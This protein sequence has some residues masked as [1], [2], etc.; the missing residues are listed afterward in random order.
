MTIRAA[1]LLATLATWAGLCA[2]GESGSSSAATSRLTPTADRAEAQANPVAVSPQPGTEDASP[3]TQVSFLGE[4]GTTVG[5]VSVVGSRSGNHP[6]KVKR[7]STGT[8]ASFVPNSPFQAGEQV[9]VHALVG[10]GSGTPEEP[11]TT[12]FT[13]AHQ[14]SVSRAEFPNNPGDPHAIQHYASAPTL[15][16]STVTITTHAQAG[17]APGYLFMAPYQGEG[18]PGPMISEQDGTLVWFHP[19]PKG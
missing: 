12:I 2:C 8:G 7:Y 14:A 6:G 17:A 11:V 18:T 15:T 1:V 10:T 4:A 19:L 3:A 5:N 16:P 13:V 9:A